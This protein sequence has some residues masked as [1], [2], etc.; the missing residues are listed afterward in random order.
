MPALRTASA[1][2]F[3]R[4]WYLYPF[5]SNTIRSI[6]SFLSF[7]P[8]DLPT[9]VLAS[10]L[11]P[12]FFIDPFKSLLLEDEET[13]DYKTIKR[14]IKKVKTFGVKIA[15]DDFG[16]GYSSFE[17]VLLYE[18]DI[19]KIDGSLV[20][21][22]VTNKSSKNLLETIAIFSKKQGIKTIAEFVENEKI[23]D[24]L[25]EIGIDYSQGYYFGK[26]QDLLFD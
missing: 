13:S 21:N 8:S 14:F 20:K 17:R 9:S 25:C 24:V 3:T 5:R 1:K 16:S 7:S 18:P 11:L 26:P 23:F 22:I 12:V 2:A 6:L 19:I 15:L 4:P 10:I